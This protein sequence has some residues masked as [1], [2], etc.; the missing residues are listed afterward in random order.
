LIRNVFERAAEAGSSIC[1]VESPKWTGSSPDLT[2]A[3]VAGEV[4]EWADCQIG[5]R[6]L[7]SA[8]IGDVS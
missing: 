1:Q 2:T 7:K 6:R 3:N 8:D 5:I 4:P